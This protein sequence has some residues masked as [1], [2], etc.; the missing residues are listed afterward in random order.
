M[1]FKLYFSKLF[2]ARLLQ[3]SKSVMVRNLVL[4][5]LGFALIFQN[6]CVKPKAG[7]IT[8][9]SVS[10]LKLLYSSSV[11]SNN[12]DFINSNDPSVDYCI[13]FQK[14]ARTEMLDKRHH[15]FFA[16]KAPLFGARF[17]DGIQ[18]GLW[19]YPVLGDRKIARSY[20][21]KVAKALVYFPSMR[22]ET[23]S[24]V[25]LHHGG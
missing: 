6:N 8:T 2:S 15:E 13:V 5:T 3:I 24:H 18:G 9:P 23:L 7:D 14:G 10:S 21:G 17:D 1:I 16:S 12:S 19:A 20:G 4:F 22:R 25:G 11:A